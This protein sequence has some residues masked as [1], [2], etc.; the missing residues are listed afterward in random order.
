MHARLLLSGF[1]LWIAGTAGLRIAGQ[2]VF[3]P[4]NPA[5]TLILFAASFPLMAWIARRLLRRFH[6]PPEAWAAGAVSLALPT[7]VLDSFSAAFFSAVYPNIP[8]GSAGIFGGWMLWLCAGAFAG[9]MFGRK[10]A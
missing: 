6:V 5:S 9:A 3:H 2:R 1:V 10:P 8:A 4:E 7:L